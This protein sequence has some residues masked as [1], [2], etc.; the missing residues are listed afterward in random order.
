MKFIELLPP[1]AVVDDSTKVGVE[2]GIVIAPVRGTLPRAAGAAVEDVAAVNR[3]AAK[4][5]PEYAV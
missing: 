4:P 5:A 2:V 1:D 3:S